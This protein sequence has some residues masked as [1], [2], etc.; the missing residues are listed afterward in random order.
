MS[1]LRLTLPQLSLQMTTPTALGRGQ[2]LSGLQLKV[3]LMNDT[4]ITFMASNQ[5]ITVARSQVSGQLQTG[6]QY[7]LQ[8]ISANQYGLVAQATSTRDQV[9]LLSKS[10]SSSLSAKVMAAFASQQPGPLTLNGT[11]MESSRQQLSIKLSSGQHIQLPAR[12]ELSVK[13]GEAVK[14]ELKQVQ[15]QWQLTLTSAKSQQ[16]TRLP[17]QPQQAASLAPVLVSGESAA[18]LSKTQLQQWQQQ[19]LIKSSKQELG[20]LLRQSPSPQIKLSYAEPGRLQARWSSPASPSAT[21]RLDDQ[22]IKQL[23]SL[24]RPEPI[25]IKAPEAGDKP[26]TGLNISRITPRPEVLLSEQGLKLSP[27]LPPRPPSPIV[28]LAQ[29]ADASTR[30]QIVGLL[31]QLQSQQS[32][33]AEGLNQLQ[34]TL[35]GLPK[36]GELGGLMNK[37]S[38]Q[39]NR[40]LP[41]GSRDDA[42]QLRQLLTLP[43][44]N[45]TPTQLTTPTSQSGF[46]G[47]LVTLLQIALS[48]RMTRHRPEQGTRLME[49]L[50]QLIQAR[51][52][53]SA[54]TAGSQ[55]PNLNN[56]AQL[57]QRHQLIRQL[58]SLLNQ[59]PGSKIGAADAAIQGQE[60]FHYTLPLGSAPHRDAELLIKREDLPEHN[61]PEEST[62]EKRWNLTMRL[63]IGEEQGLLAKAKLY[64][65]ELEL[66]L[67]AD[68]PHVKNKAEKYLPLL[69][70]RLETLGLTVTDTRCEL[71]QIPK[72]LKPQ[73][74]HLFETHA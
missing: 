46:M 56:F 6:Q 42:Q 1:D 26:P 28:N 53:A 55:L 23:K 5:P 60:L 14:L 40:S 35:K 41:Q 74:Y 9:Q 31:R 51:G 2:D 25:G 16:S 30:Q 34:A 4:A 49:G 39:L 37:I 27:Q 52:E 38:E 67:Y 70:E 45:I 65:Q 62:G 20:Q 61:N 43:A 57:E 17:L 72:S 68:Q 15:Q 59:H 22:G 19:L 29:Q 32:S 58:S 50:S 3:K 47:G 71:G 48:A 7:Q 63:T 10:L 54:P 24:A 8:Q 18:T 73:P 36:S 21:L 13:P 11:V 33:P 44:L 12:P 69:K 64:R 66:H